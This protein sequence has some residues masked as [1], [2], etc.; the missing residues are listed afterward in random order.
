M[1]EP[2]SDM[3]EALDAACA[4]RED[5]YEGYVVNAVIDACYRSARSKR[6]EPVVLDVWRAAQPAPAP[7]VE[8]QHVGGRVLIKEERMPDGTMKQIL[9]DPATGEI[10]ESTVGAA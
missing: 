6:W 3:F 9:R 7:R 2:F 5:F 8:V 10:T 1:T 4:P